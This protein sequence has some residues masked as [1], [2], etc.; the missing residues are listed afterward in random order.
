VA[1]HVRVSGKAEFC[2]RAG[3][4]YHV[5]K[6]DGAERRPTRLILDDLEATRRSFAQE[7]RADHDG[8]PSR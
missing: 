6:A 5:G 4:L 8:K 3:S 1:Q 2:R 7:V